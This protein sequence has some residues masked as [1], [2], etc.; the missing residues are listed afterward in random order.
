[1]RA[2]ERREDALSHDR[3]VDALI[4]LLDSE[5]ENGLTSCALATRLATGPGAG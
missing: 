2:S 4:E 1:M 3:I 5:G